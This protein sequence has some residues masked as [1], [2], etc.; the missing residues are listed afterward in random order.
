MMEDKGSFL[1]TKRPEKGTSFRFCFSLFWHVLFLWNQS[2]FT[3]VENLNQ[4]FALIL[5]IIIF[6]TDDINNVVC[7]INRVCLIY[8][9]FLCL[10]RSCGY[11][12]ARPKIISLLGNSVACRGIGKPASLYAF[13]AI[14]LLFLNN[15]FILLRKQLSVKCYSIYFLENASVG[16][17]SSCF[18]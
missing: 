3:H 6:N 13:R 9:D 1:L 10:Y 11:W 2:L 12:S 8:W 4:N 14:C 7:H 18:K 16:E 15:I 17:N 5:G